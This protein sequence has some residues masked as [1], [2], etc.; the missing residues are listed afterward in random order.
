[1]SD[2]NLWKRIRGLLSGKTAAPAASSRKAQGEI[3]PAQ[4][5]ETPPTERTA[6]QE[7]VVQE[8][9]PRSHAETA[10]R[11]KKPAQF[12]FAKPS[13]Y[14]SGWG[15]DERNNKNS[16]YSE[17]GKDAALM[18]VGEQTFVV[19]RINRHAVFRERGDS[20]ERAALFIPQITERGWPYKVT[21]IP[22]AEFA[23]IVRQWEYGRYL[24]YVA[25]F[26][27]PGQCA[28]L[29]FVPDGRGYALD[30]YQ[31]SIGWFSWRKA[32]TQPWAELLTAAPEELRPLCQTL[33]DTQINPRSGNPYIDP[34]SLTDIPHRFLSG[35][36][37][38][39]R[40]LTL[41][42]VQT[43]PDV[44]AN[45]L[46]PVTI[47]YR[48]QTPTKRAGTTRMLQGKQQLA[49]GRIPSLCDLALRLNTFVGLAWQPRPPHTQ[50][51]R[52]GHFDK[53]V[54][55][56]IVTVQPPSAHERAES[57]LIL[58]DWLEGKVREPKR[59]HWLGID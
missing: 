17:K 44:F 25:D 40:R 11:Q 14:F 39:L 9:T 24:L 18:I 48:A 54:H 42:I 21:D 16:Y 36:E 57:L 30:E 10:G 29:G 26:M 23:R 35:S 19:R 8:A 52:L 50:P 37:D 47:T 55:R 34:A 12:T 49:G 33:F 59:L 41:A 46:E 20:D 1:M 43:D 28:Y 51:N 27:Q 58:A 56:I 53:Q 15:Y 5:V 6:I 45:S 4:E 22:E 31:T 2:W 3:P 32:T 38:E 13:L 7:A